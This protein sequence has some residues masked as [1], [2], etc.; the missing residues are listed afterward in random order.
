M[1]DIHNT[2]TEEVLKNTDF[3]YLIDKFKDSGDHNLV[4]FTILHNNGKL[5]DYL[6]NFESDNIKVLKLNNFIREKCIEASKP[7]IKNFGMFLIIAF[8]II[9][10]MIFSSLKK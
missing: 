2:K 8:I 3:E 9:V 1:K 4:N 7:A 5:L 10:I 6:K